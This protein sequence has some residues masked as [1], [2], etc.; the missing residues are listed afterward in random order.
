M[1]R[2]VLNCNENSTPLQPDF[3]NM[4]SNVERLCIHYVALCWQISINKNLGGVDNLMG[5][6]KS[7]FERS[8]KRWRVTFTFSHV[9]RMVGGF[10]FLLLRGV[11]IFS[12][13]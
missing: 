7:T 11:S 4:L 10:S 12:L 9:S 1:K 8:H 6:H 5:T 13:F 2:V 3:I